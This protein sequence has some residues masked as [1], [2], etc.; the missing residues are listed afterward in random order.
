[1]FAF[2]S[3]VLLSFLLSELSMLTNASNS[4]R[5]YGDNI[6]SHH[7]PLVAY[8]DELVQ[9][10]SGTAPVPSALLLI[11]LPAHPAANMH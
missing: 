7:V 3:V 1:M 5:A 4:N 6:I 11:R 8:V 2:K 10:N 9:Q